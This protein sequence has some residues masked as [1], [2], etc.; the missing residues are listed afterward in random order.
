[1]TNDSTTKSGG[2]EYTFRDGN[3]IKV[4]PKKSDGGTPKYNNY[5]KRAV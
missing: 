3:I 1:M 2:F 5:R 4:F